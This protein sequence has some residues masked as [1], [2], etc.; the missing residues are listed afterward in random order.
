MRLCNSATNFFLSCLLVLVISQ[1]ACPGK[2]SLVGRWD[3][4]ASGNCYL[5]YPGKLEFFKDGTYVGA[6]P[7]WNGGK[8]E[9]VEKSRI[10]VDTL[11]GPGVY[12]FKISDGFLIFQNDNNCE[13]R[14]V[15]VR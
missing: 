1:S 12:T 7:N 14:Y 6:L 10:K 9:V 13:F 8:Y 4:V 5:L 3:R 15:R 2:A 11:T